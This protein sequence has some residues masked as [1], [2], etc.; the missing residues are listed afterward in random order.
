MH[1][2]L[3]RV[4]IEIAAAILVG[5]LAGRRRA[6]QRDEELEREAKF[7]EAEEAE[8]RRAGEA[9]RAEEVRRTEAAAAAKQAEAS[10]APESTAGGRRKKRTVQDHENAKPAADPSLSVRTKIST[11]GARVLARMKGGEDGGTEADDE[12]RRHD[13]RSSA[14]A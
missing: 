11:F 2:A 6:R 7:K 5:Y 8:A 3:V 12:L 13:A 9:A 10:P 4:W 1:P 14:G